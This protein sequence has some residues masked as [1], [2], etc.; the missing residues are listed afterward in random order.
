MKKSNLTE[1]QIDVLNALDDLHYENE[2]NTQSTH[3]SSYYT[4]DEIMSK[5]FSNS[6]TFYKRDNIRKCITR[7]DA[8]GFIDTITDK[9]N[10]YRITN[11]G[12]RCITVDKRDDDYADREISNFVH[13]I[14]S[15]NDEF[16]LNN[17]PAV[18]SDNVDDG[19]VV[20][21]VVTEGELLNKKDDDIVVLNSNEQSICNIIGGIDGVKYSHIK[22]LAA[23]FSA[24]NKKPVDNDTGICYNTDTLKNDLECLSNDC[25]D[26][27]SAL[28]KLMLECSNIVKHI[29]DKL[30]G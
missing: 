21:P 16:K 7:L 6:N 30:K 14:E 4:L 13:S 12:I 1:M 24:V 10:K 20:L 28:S 3:D 22:Q 11:N 17:L 19:I 2:K 18:C 29:T 27:I 9:P 23:L 5:L 15:I 25:V 8:Y 26:A